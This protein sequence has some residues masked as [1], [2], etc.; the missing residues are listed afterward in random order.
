VKIH[1]SVNGES[2]GG[3]RRKARKLQ[4]ENGIGEKGTAEQLNQISK[5]ASGK[6]DEIGISS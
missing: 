1:S 6:E 4:K 2:W 5:E 3:H